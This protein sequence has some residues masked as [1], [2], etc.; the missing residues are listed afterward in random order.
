MKINK[1]LAEYKNQINRVVGSFGCGRRT[2]QPKHADPKWH[3]PTPFSRL[4]A[5]TPDSN[6]KSLGQLPDP[7]VVT[8]LVVN[9]L[10]FGF[11]A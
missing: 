6:L 7:Y 3:T 1:I 10:N 5:E 2:R 9:G 11:R 4:I 8:D